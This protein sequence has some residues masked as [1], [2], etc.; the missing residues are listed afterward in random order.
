MNFV[1]ENPD[2]S[3]GMLHSKDDSYYAAD[4]GD[5][6]LEEFFSRPIL[7]NT[8]SWLTTATAPLGA[9]FDP[10][11][12]FFS[13]PRVMNR[14]ANYRN[15]R[16]NLKLKITVNGSQF[17]FGRAMVC[18][19]PIGGRDEMITNSSLM[20]LSQLPHIFIDPGT[21][22]GG[23][24]TIPYLL[25]RNSYN[26]VTGDYKGFTQ[27]LIAGL[28][29]LGHLGGS[30]D[31]V[32]INTYCWA[33]N[34]VLSCPTNAEPTALVPQAGREPYSPQSGD[35]YGKGIISRSA[36]A[37]AHKAGMLKD[38][39]AIRPY[40][41]ATQIGAG[42]VGDIAR[43]FGFARPNNISETIYAKPRLSESFAN[44]DSADSIP[45]LTFDS[46]Q[47]TTVDPRTMGLGAVDHMAFANIAQR[48]AFLTQFVWSNT[49]SSTSTLLWNTGV[50]PWL[51]TTS[52]VGGA[53]SLPPCAFI[54]A[55]FTKW[56][57]SMKFRFQICSSPMH[58]GRIRISYD[59]NHSPTGKSEYNTV[60]SEVV[61]IGA[62]NDFSIVV[63][64]HSH[65]SYLDVPAIG[66]FPPGSLFG[67]LPI[68]PINADIFNGF[69]LVQIEND[70]TTPGVPTVGVGDVT[71]NI[72]VSACDD[73]EVCDPSPT[74]M[75]TFMYLPQS[76]VEN[77]EPQ[78]GTEDLTSDSSAPEGAPIL[79]VFGNA[80][81]PD[82]SL[83]YHGDPIVSIRS[84]VKRYTF[85]RRHASGTIAAGINPLS[86]IWTVSSFPK[87]KGKGPAGDVAGV[88][89]VHLTPITYFAPA[90]LGFRG[91][92]RHKM[93][94]IGPQQNHM[95][96]SISR[97]RTAT[98]DTNAVVAFTAP[99]AGSGMA[100]KD[101]LGLANT[102]SGW[103]GSACTS[104]RISPLMEA[105]IPYSSTF[106]YI[107]TRFKNPA[108]FAP[109]MGMKC[110]VR[111]P[112]NPSPT[113][114]YVDDYVSAADDFSLFYFIAVPL[115][116]KKTLT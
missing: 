94:Y 2:W 114:M 10:W 45:K 20:Q 25:P 97:W 24:L 109:E 54:V 115:I 75:D 100:Y 42:A 76:G 61:D 33:E 98:A 31:P 102:P 62:T 83:I 101:L 38:V 35:E 86:W 59:P 65:K 92:I 17:H 56:R 112:A 52:L 44:I 13:N 103:A 32:T 49:S 90:F 57:G 36:Y 34:M 14:I 15:M 105:E 69:L 113:A 30:N 1:D 8:T 96:T 64:W 12:L 60:M 40:A 9:I 74:F 39:P 80:C 81:K 26:I 29:K 48:E 88:A 22:Q 18:H 77:F 71:V 23:T 53:T 108:Q 93:M 41:T 72:Y 27:V 66:S 4:T 19:S 47:E 7:I 63:G 68:T 116:Y 85:Y 84:A 70:L 37:I 55:P 51:H 87:Y 58:R 111:L 11:D 106:R 78:S 3:V 95:T 50:A 16:C 43:M 110:E 46:K 5:V 6:S 104:A 28:T 79:R 91:G 82:H 67:T 73:L 107:P 89:Y 99:P 21:S